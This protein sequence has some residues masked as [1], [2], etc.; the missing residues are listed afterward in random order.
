VLLCTSFFNL[1]IVHYFCCRLILFFSCDIV[2][3]P[4]GV[5]LICSGNRPAGTYVLVFTVFQVA[6][7]LDA[8]LVILT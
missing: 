4:V 5:C 2:M 8:S 3:H 1:F 6:Q 7:Y